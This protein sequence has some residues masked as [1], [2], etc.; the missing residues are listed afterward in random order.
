MMQFEPLDTIN[1]VIL[2]PP[3]SGPVRS[4]GEQAM[5]HGEEDGEF[6]CKP[7]LALTRELLLTVQPFEHESRPDAP[8]LSADCRPVVEG[9]DH[10]CLGGKAPARS[11]KPFQLAA[12]VQVFDTPKRGDHLLAD[13]RAFT[14][15]FDDL[16]RDRRRSSGGS[17]WPLI[18]SLAS[19][20]PREQYQDPS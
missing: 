6:E 15:A 14:T 18:P 12:L 4:S 16:Q 8:H 3:I 10:D 11:Q 19:L 2:P 5:Q 17:T 1:P 20:V 7:M 13:S 9:I